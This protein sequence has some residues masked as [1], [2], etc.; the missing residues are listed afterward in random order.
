MGAFFLFR[1]DAEIDH[2]AVNDCFTAKGFDP[3][4]QFTLNSMHL[5]LFQKQ[6]L[7]RNNVIR[8]EAGNFLFAVGSLSYKGQS[9]AESLSTLLSDFRSANMDYSRLHGAFCA[10]LLIESKLSILF[11]EFGMYRLYT[12]NRR[13]FF[14]S[15]F[16]AALSA[17]KHKA[18]LNKDALLEKCV[19][20]Y[21]VGPQTLAAEIERLTPAMA[22]TIQSSD[23]RIICPKAIVETDMPANRKEAIRRQI[24]VLNDYFHDIGALLPENEADI[25]LSGG[26]DSRLLLMLAMA[27]FDSLLV[28]THWTGSEHDQN[29]SIAEEL[30]RINGLDL[31]TAKT[32]PPAQLERS[33]FEAM[34]D[35]SLCYYDG[36]CAYTIGCFSQTHT[37]EYRNAVLNS[38]PL[39]LNGIGG[40]IYRNHYH[41]REGK[42]DFRLWLQNRTFFL[43][44][45]RLIGKRCMINDLMDSIAE[46]IF[47]QLRKMPQTA[48]SS[49]FL[50]RYFSEVRMPFCDGAVNHA[51]QQIAFFFT[52]FTEPHNVKAAYAAH[53]FASRGDDFQV[54]L[55]KSIDL[56]T[57]EVISDRGFSPCSQPFKH[58]LNGIIKSHMPERVIAWRRQIQSLRGQ[59]RSFESS[60]MHLM[61]EMPLFKQALEAVKDTLP[62]LHWKVVQRDKAHVGNLFFTGH[63][64]NRYQHKLYV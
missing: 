59:G 48:V 10:I 7:Q 40:E 24:D 53:Q 13:T 62:E 63:F 52:P 1:S 23:V 37:R 15:S 22:S 5:W 56:K 29:R 3:P 32:S 55:M 19:R 21:I 16:L 2:Q 58:L 12:D 44:A 49:L 35:S 42:T 47:V 64:L 28:H 17:F 9:H 33:A 31:Y 30:C 50:R 61:N 26:Y 60:F 36:N 38:C 4:L 11:D 14:S 45:C 25:G 46:R 57:A 18:K 27:H 20:G 51:N 54:H 41:T 43:N 6:L 39:G 8:D 34:A